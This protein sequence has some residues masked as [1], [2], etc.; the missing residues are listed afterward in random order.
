[1]LEFPQALISEILLCG[2]R[3]R[4]EHSDL[5]ATLLILSRLRKTLHPDNEQRWSDASATNSSD[6][7]AR[8]VKLRLRGEKLARRRALFTA[9]EAIGRRQSYQ[10]VTESASIR[11]ELG[12]VIDEGSSG[13]KVRA[14]RAMRFIASDECIPFIQTGL[15]DESRWVQTTALHTLFRLDLKKEK[16]RQVLINFLLNKFRESLK[17]DWESLSAETLRRNF[18]R[19]AGLFVGLLKE[20][21][22]MGLAFFALLLWIT[23]TIL[24]LTVPLLLLLAALFCLVVLLGIGCAL[25]PGAILGLPLLTRGIIK[26]PGVSRSRIVILASLD[27]VLTSLMIAAGLHYG[28]IY[29]GASLGIF[30]LLLLCSWPFNGEAFAKT[31]KFRQFNRCLFTAVAGWFSYRSGQPLKLT[32][33]LAVLFIAQ[34]AWTFPRLFPWLAAAFYPRKRKFVRV[35]DF[36]NWCGR[37]LFNVFR[38]PWWFL[39]WLK[40]VTPGVFA[41]LN[42]MLKSPAVREFPQRVNSSVRR[43]EG[44]ARLV[45]TN[46]QRRVR[47][48]IKAKHFLIAATVIVSLAAALTFVRIK[49]GHL[50]EAQLKQWITPLLHSAMQ[51]LR[52]S[53]LFTLKPYLYL[54]LGILTLLITCSIVLIG[55]YLLWDELLFVDRIRLRILLRREAHPPDSPEKFLKFVLDMIKNPSWP[56]GLRVHAASNLA[57]VPELSNEKD[58]TI[59]LDLAIEDLPLEVRDAIEQSVQAAQDRMGRGEIREGII[60][61]ALIDQQV[62]TLYQAGPILQPKI[63]RALQLGL[64]CSI[65]VGLAQVFLLGVHRLIDKAALAEM[66]LGVALIFVYLFFE[67]PRLR[68]WSLLAGLIVMSIGITHPL[69]DFLV[70]ATWPNFLNFGMEFVDSSTLRAFFFPMVLACIVAQAGN[71]LFL[72]ASDTKIEVKYGEGSGIM[73]RRMA[74]LEKKP[75]VLST[76]LFISLAATTIQ[77]EPLQEYLDLRTEKMPSFAAIES[78]SAIQLNDIPTD[79]RVVRI[80]LVAARKEPELVFDGSL[81]TGFDAL[82]SNLLQDDLIYTPSVERTFAPIFKPIVENRRPVPNDQED[83][84][85]SVFLDEVWLAARDGEIKIWQPLPPQRTPCIGWSASGADKLTLDPRASCTYDFRVRFVA[86]VY[87]QRRSARVRESANLQNALDEFDLK[88]A[89]G[90]RVFAGTLSALTRATWSP[91]F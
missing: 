87:N 40:R 1:M 8:W 31:E 10:G 81:P 82:V 91:I 19:N 34:F 46:L 80:A 38:S 78:T 71:T 2:A 14:L 73:A 68:R 85:D 26:P 45:K 51:L 60:D 55:I 32:V 20:R 50:T 7:R 33:A 39:K 75:A 29:L 18:N 21:G 86:I 53:L 63:E 74:R 77:A 79:G 59:L 83:I 36:L 52:G 69:Q 6:V 66:A 58:L 56:T 15:S 23:S 43:L 4:A 25:L 76:A 84:E 61:M 35:L 17:W 22:G 44:P 64:G 28:L 42:E 30:Y 47:Q 12:V 37:L 41:A 90:T 24:L 11:D 70:D 67:P 72:L 3:W 49:V 54:S 9:A 89:S 16:P 62:E 5:P 27:Y 48:S 88:P 65:L 57:E 13:Q